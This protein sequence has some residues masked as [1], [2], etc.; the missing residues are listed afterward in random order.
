MQ[1]T[2]TYEPFV[3][4]A[5]LMVAAGFLCGLLFFKSNG[6]TSASMFSISAI[7]CFGLAMADHRLSSDGQALMVAIGVV[8][9]IAAVAAFIARKQQE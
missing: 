1:E 5:V 3:L 8:S 4:I 9:L 6:V 2:S 7:G